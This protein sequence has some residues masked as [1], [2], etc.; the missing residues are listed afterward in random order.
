MH[1]AAFFYGNRGA[2]YHILV[3]FHFFFGKFVVEYAFYIHYVGRVGVFKANKHCLVYRNPQPA[4]FM[5]RVERRE[6]FRF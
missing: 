5:Q 6:H 1:A 4:F 2:A 3:L